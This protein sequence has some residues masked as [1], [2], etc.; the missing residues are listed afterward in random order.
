MKPHSTRT[1]V[2]TALALLLG[3]TLLRAQNAPPDAST[4]EEVIVADTAAAPG[5]RTPHFKGKESPTLATALANLAESNARIATLLAK[6]TL[7]PADLLQVHVLSYTL[8][9]AL[10][11]LAEEQA[12]LAALV[13]EIHVAS[14][15]LDAA[16]VKA[17]GAVYLRDA[18]P[19]TR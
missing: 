2:V 18:A 8:E 3:A 14:E 4:A 11:R 6:R 7:E 13:E 12:R 17:R 1:L 9:K 10:A 15:R 5:E 16:T 19:L